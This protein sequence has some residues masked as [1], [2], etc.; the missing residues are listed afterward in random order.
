LDFAIIGQYDGV[1]NPN[2]KENELPRSKLTGCLRHSL[3]N[4]TQQAAGN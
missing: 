2:I 1:M 4:T 3:F